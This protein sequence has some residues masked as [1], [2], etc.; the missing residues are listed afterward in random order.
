MATLKIGVFGATGR[1]GQLIINTLRQDK[2]AGVSVIYV[3]G[4]LD[5][6]VDPSILI[7]NDMSAFLKASDVIIDFHFQMLQKNS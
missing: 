2:H 3:R 7:T 4:D 6:S 5:F 1:V